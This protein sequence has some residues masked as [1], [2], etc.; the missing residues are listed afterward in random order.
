MAISI[1]T[2]IFAR[3]LPGSREGRIG[4]IAIETTYALFYGVG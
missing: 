1:P 2:N 3:K 4:V